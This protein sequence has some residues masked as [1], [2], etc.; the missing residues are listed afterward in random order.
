MKKPRL[1]TCTYDSQGKPIVLVPLANH[2]EPAIIDA[3]DFDALMKAGV[4]DQWFLNDN[5]SGYCYVRCCAKMGDNLM[6]LARLIRCPAVGRV[7]RYGDGNRL[8]LRR[9]NLGVSRGNAKSRERQ[10]R[11]SAAC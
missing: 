2:P 11:E 10:I 8:N 1:P 6:T 5:G 9:A 3:D 4:S 7:I